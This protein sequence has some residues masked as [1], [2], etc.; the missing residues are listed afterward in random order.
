MT[1][2]RSG[3]S[4]AALLA[5][6]CLA[7]P[8]PAEGPSEGF[9]LRPAPGFES[10]SFSFS[11]KG[12]AQEDYRSYRDWEVQETDLG[13]LRRPES[14]FRRGRAGVETSWGPLSGE[15]TLEFAGPGTTMKDA[16]LELRLARELRLRGGFF[17]PPLGAEF[18]TS[19][20]KIDFV[21]RAMLSSELAPD[22][23]W[24]GMAHGELG[25]RVSY[26]L[27]LFVGDGRDRRSRA[28][29]TAAGRVL[30]TVA[31]GVEVGG[32]VMLGQVEADPAGGAL[33]PTPK[34]LRGVSPTGYVFSIPRFA[35]G[36]RLRLNAEAA[37]VRGPVSLRAEYLRASEERKGQ[38]SVFDDLPRSVGSGWAVAATWL[39]TGGSKKD[40]AGKPR[41]SLFRGPG[42]VELAA[43]YESLSFDDDGP[44]TGF[45]GFGNR[46][47]N[48]RPADARGLAG[49]LSWW[50]SAYFR[51]M[52]DVV[53][54]RYGD[55][56]LAPEPGRR[57]NYV[58]L[59]GRLQVQLP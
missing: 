26:Q 3:V 7:V 30:V 35:H 15:F 41:R 29:T 57:G 49:G 48:I 17:K 42:A 59:L 10:G 43:R 14:Q 4:L 32:A 22:R 54:E 2:R 23:E 9:H 6:S 24:G 40:G 38:G 19:A 56:L 12:Y 34:G 39:L 13:P 31:K 46:A 16:Y 33:D 55:T 11:L 44:D 52:G 50:P 8:A 28:E 53:V 47:R 25:K 37:W 36:E 51:I 18:L 1:A 45:A 58:T 5:A 27:G 21:E 20:S